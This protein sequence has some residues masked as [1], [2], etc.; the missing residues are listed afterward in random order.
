MRILVICVSLLFAMDAFAQQKPPTPPPAPPFGNPISLEQ[1]ETALQAAIAEAKSKN[2]HEA[3]AAVDTSGELVHFSKM[4]GTS[5]SAIA[6][7]QAKAVTAARYR[8]P[9]RFF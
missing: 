5:F 4:D 9:T 8:R 1:A 6:L 7:A 2:L 3:V